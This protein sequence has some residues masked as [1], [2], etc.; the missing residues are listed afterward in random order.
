MTQLVLHFFFLVSKNTWS[1]LDCVKHTEFFEFS[2]KYYF[3]DVLTSVELSCDI[4]IFCLFH[5][6]AQ[7]IQRKCSFSCSTTCSVCL[8]LSGVFIDSSMTVRLAYFKN[9]TYRQ[10]LYSVSVVC[11]PSSTIFLACGLAVNYLILTCWGSKSISEWI[12]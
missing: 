4:I 6:R 2:S 1:F 11:D 5:G 10:C 7:G 8:S 9:T 3:N 12:K